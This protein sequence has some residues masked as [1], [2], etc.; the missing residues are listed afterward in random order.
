MTHSLRARAER[1]QRASVKDCAVM[2]FGG[3]D[4]NYCINMKTGRRVRVTELIESAY[5]KLHFKWSV[6]L[7]VFGSVGKDK[8]QKAVQVRTSEPLLMRQ[9]QPYLEEHHRT[10]IE[11]VPDTQLHNIGW[12]ARTDCY[13]WDEEAAFKILEKYGVFENKIDKKAI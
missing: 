3:A 6:L 10:L 1:I 2:W 11:T 5:N 13:E 7:M 12:I 8:Y 4:F 9:L